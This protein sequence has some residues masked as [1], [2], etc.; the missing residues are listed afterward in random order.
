ALLAGRRSEHSQNSAHAQAEKPKGNSP[1]MPRGPRQRQGLFE[2]LVT[3]Q[4]VAR[5]MSQHARRKERLDTRERGGFAAP[6]ERSLDPVPPLVKMASL[7]PEPLQC[8]D[9]PQLRPPTP[10][11]F[12]A[13]RLRLGPLQGCSQVVVF[14]LQPIQP[15]ELRVSEQL[16]L[17]PFCQLKVE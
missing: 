17:G 15:F 3:T 4:I 13:G 9:Q 10:G 5:K 12:G 7:D 11:R 14:S 16:R 1:L 2:E 8:A 6:R